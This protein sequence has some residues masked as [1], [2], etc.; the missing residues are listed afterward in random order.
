MKRF[1][2]P[3]LALASCVAPAQTIGAAYLLDVKTGL[4][5]E[6]V[7]TSIGEIRKPLG[8]NFNLA[9]DGFAGL[10]SWDH[11]YP[12]VWVSGRVPLAENFN[13]KFGPAFTYEENRVRFPGLVIGFE[14]RF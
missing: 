10:N 4:T 6:V 5:R 3:A 13:L 7:I 9:I 11:V 8:L 14:I 2:I 1:I 12:G